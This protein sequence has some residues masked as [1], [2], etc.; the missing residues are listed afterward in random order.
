MAWRGVG[1]S[2]VV[3]VACG[4]TSRTAPEEPAA[5]TTTTTTTVTAAATVTTTTGVEGP[6]VPDEYLGCAFTEDCV[7]THPG[8]CD[9]C[10]PAS[11]ENM[12]AVNRAAAPEYH[13][14][15]CGSQ[16][17]C[18]VCVPLPNPYL[19]A[20]CVEGRCELFDLFES[21]IAECTS[22][23]QCELRQADCCACG[24]D[25]SWIAINGDRTEEYEELMCDPPRICDAC[26]D[27]PDVTASTPAAAM[28][29]VCS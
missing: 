25:A 21:E 26:P 1:F 20:L 15:T 23:E 19:H 22:N 13:A 3:A 12:V 11:S 28:G 6:A 17:G 24:T 18:T 14:S 2:L 29:A 27:P 9:H 7:V 4:E 16:L 10:M 5:D 8:C